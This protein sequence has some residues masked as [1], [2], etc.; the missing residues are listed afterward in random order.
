MF[1]KA[2]I[3]EKTYKDYL[4]QIASLD[5]LSVKDKL[6]L[7]QNGM[8]FVI[9]F[10]EKEYIISEQGFINESGETPPFMI[11]VI[12]SKYLLLCPD[13]C[14]EDTGWVSFKDFKVTSHFLNVN[15][16]ASDAEKPIAANFSGKTDL[17]MNACR[18]SGGI[19]YDSMDISYD[20]IMKF[21]AFPRISLLLLFNDGDEE[22]PARSSLLFQKQA[23]YYLDPESL[24]MTGAVLA[25]NLIKYAR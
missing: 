19:P 1:P 14:H 5:L 2:E 24:A 4:V 20:L 18:A 11:C 25:R 21:N 12:L 13:I 6:G 23:E 9:P 16:F 7:K 15:Y 8:Q 3:F 17:L 22:F 10:F